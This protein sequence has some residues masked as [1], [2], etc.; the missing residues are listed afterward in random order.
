MFFFPKMADQ[1]AITKNFL[2]LQFALVRESRMVFASWRT[3]ALRDGCEWVDPLF[4]GVSDRRWVL[5]WAVGEGLFKNFSKTI[6]YTYVYICIYIYE[7]YYVGLDVEAFLLGG[8][9]S[10][11]CELLVAGRVPY[12]IMYLYMYIYTYTCHFVLLF[13]MG[14]SCGIALE[15]RAANGG[16]YR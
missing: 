16:L 8:R 7:M 13:L 5:F 1:V 9:P 4:W 6:A 10:F 11:R 12:I 3:G 15:A 2:K 14:L